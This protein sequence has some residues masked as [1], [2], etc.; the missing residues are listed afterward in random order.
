MRLGPSFSSHQTTHIPSTWAD[1][2]NLP[3][4]QRNKIIQGIAQERFSEEEAQPMYG[5]ISSA[6]KNTLANLQQLITAYRQENTFT[7]R[8]WHAV[9]GFFGVG[10]ESREV[11]RLEKELDRL[12]SESL[13]SS[14]QSC[15][16]E[17]E[18]KT[19]IEKFFAT[20]D[21]HK[22]TVL[23]RALFHL[24]TS[25]EVNQDQVL[26]VLLEKGANPN[27]FYP[28]D[29]PSFVFVQQKREAL[30]QENN[31]S[32]LTGSGVIKEATAFGMYV[33]SENASKGGVTQLKQR[34]GGLEKGYVEEFELSTVPRVFKKIQTILS[35][36]SFGNVKAIVPVT[37]LLTS[38][39][40]VNLG[41]NV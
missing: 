31:E 33:L 40:K 27:R 8:C 6:E 1:F 32:P 12:Q 15:N 19:Q 23:D 21:I 29:H 4:E 22:Q 36:S 5:Q 13:I 25:L 34:S 7:T 38:S 30:D 24:V 26:K 20:S 11:Q 10:C 28:L 2:R 39:Q 14:L 41:L 3:N 17:E 16:T 9:K 35:L 18:L 37:G